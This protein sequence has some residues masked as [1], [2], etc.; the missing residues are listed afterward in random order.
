VRDRAEDEA[1]I[2]AARPPAPRDG[3]RRHATQGKLAAIIAFDASTGRKR[4][5][6][7]LARIDGGAHC[8]DDLGVDPAG[9]IYVSDSFAPAVYAVDKNLRAKVLVRSERSRGENFNL[10]S[11]VYHP[12]GVLLVGKHNSREVFRISIKPKPDVQP[13]RLSAKIPG[14]DGME[15]VNRNSVVIAQNARA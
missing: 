12:D 6:I 2:R 13:V 14:A 1:E 4:H 10:D 7:D 8:A 3:G 9:N 11:V 15:L 5:Y